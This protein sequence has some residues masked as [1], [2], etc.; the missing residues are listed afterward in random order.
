LIGSGFP[1]LL[2]ALAAQSAAAD[3]L[4]QLADRLPKSALIVETRARPLATREAV[5]EALV[6][7]VRT[8]SASKEEFAAAQRLAEAYAVAWSDPFLVNEVTRFAARP[9]AQRAA[10]VRVDS[11]RR[12]G[13]A[14]Y[15]REGVTTATVLWRRS[16]SRAQAIRDSTAIAAVLGNL[17]SG[18]LD[19]RRLDSAKAYL[20]RAR[21]LAAAVGDVR[22]EGN[23]V[24]ELAN[25]S[26]ELGDL[27]A[28]RKGFTQ[29]LALRERIGDTRGIAADQH[30]LGLLAQETGDLE[31][32]RRR[33]EAALALNRREGREEVAATNLVGLAGLASL[34]GDYARADALYRDALAIWRAREQ[35]ADA[36]DALH[37]LGQLELRRGDYPA[38]RAALRESLSIYDRTGRVAD[39]LMVRREL[40][41][42]LAAVGELQGALD[43]L[44]RAQH[45]ADSARMPLRIRASIALARGDLAV[46][47]NALP[48]AERLYGQA[49]RLSRQA[50]DPS[51][52]AAAEQGQGL[53]LVSQED[54]PRALTLLQGALRTQVAAGDQRAAALTRLSLGQ[55]SRVR[56][57]ASLA[58]RQ[59]ARA[60][61]DLDRLGDPVGA[62]AAVGE[63]AA[64]EADSRPAVAESLYRAGIARLRDRIAPE[65]AW[66]LH[67]GLGLARGAQGAVDEAARELR[68]AIAEIDRPSRSL[69]LAERRSTFLAD[70]WEVFAQLALLERG[71]GRIGAAF[72]AS[73]RLRASE[74]RE[75]L[76][77][78]RVGLPS[79]T[80]ATIVS[81][82]QDLRRRIGELTRALGEPSAA[83]EVLRG[84]DVSMSGG[85]ARGALLQAQEAYAELLLE[86]RE[87]APR[88]ATLVSRD[89][90]TWREVARRLAPD[91]AFIEYLV[92]DSASLAF[93]VTRDTVVVEDLGLGRHDL[94]RL[95][96]F[97][98]GTLEQQRSPRTDSLWRGP[99]RRLYQHLIA[100]L[101]ENGFLAGKT[102]L[103]LVP[104]AELHYLPFAALIDGEAS[105]GGGRYLVERYELTVTPSA[106]VWLT[107]GDRPASR[108]P[109]GVLA[110]AP[111]PDALPASRQ[112]VAA[113]AR[114][115]G[116]GA[117]VLTGS[118]AT[119]E[120]FRREA[121][122]RQVIH[123]ATYGILNK[124]NPLFS[125][126]ELAPGGAHDGRLEAHEVFGLHLE[127]ELVVL[128]ACQT[129]LGSGTVADV[130]AGDDWVGLSRA[131]LHAGAKQ[132][133]A[134]LWAVDDWSTA[135]LMERFYQGFESGSGPARALAQ[136]QRTLLAAPATAHPF[137]WAGF[138]VV[139]GGEVTGVNLQRGR[140]P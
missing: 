10:K 53:L 11:L 108:A 45:Q 84:P 106:S 97:V 38:A 104:H 103:V 111:R 94:A 93:L 14:A 31:E 4:R 98:R 17:G 125:F 132:V 82:E 130:P 99:L 62:A 16:L 74:M 21:A 47:M 137:Y 81:Q 67:A 121:P 133:V 131:F 102:R 3:S 15:H 85:V 19:Q 136:A 116:T 118:A 57:D 59:L 86:M 65:I 35:W 92:S 124:Q 64:L 79:D 139:G 54:Y 76:A 95:V 42:A 113:V 88:H 72:E 20:E 80:T 28:A 122:S 48:S 115:A 8:P 127:T 37:G 66:S 61:A 109:Y 63:W 32:A 100:P 120:A 77:R 50:G 2:A 75:V 41:G 68:A 70:K 112:E 114:L 58:R 138:V 49:Q 110:L 1:F 96:E 39:A 140:S 24:G 13:V 107:L 22:V 87:R 52:A 7:T 128:S 83:R 69:A 126:V 129:G 25:V 18:F 134:S 123:L 29:A 119:E 23:A 12:A 73:E 9:P 56:G 51:G 46:Q 60:A 89:P 105:N 36:A 43:Q 55:L 6:R 135:G 91:Q 44:G 101:Q 34:A 90:A 71:R 78:G 40:A 27:A 5:A 117:L 26:K 33:F 30:N